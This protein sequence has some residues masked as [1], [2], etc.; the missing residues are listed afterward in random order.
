MIFFYAESQS[1]RKI[2]SGF[3]LMKRETLLIDNFRFFF[4][5]PA[6]FVT[7]TCFL[8]AA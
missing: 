6:T 5:S 7:L 4:G 3:E 8:Q 1:Y 2:L